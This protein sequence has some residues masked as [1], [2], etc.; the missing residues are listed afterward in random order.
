[1]MPRNSDGPTVLVTGAGGGV[2][3]S[4]LKCLQD[5]RYRVVA[6]DSDPHAAGLYA[7]AR[8]RVVPRATEPHYVEALKE[9][10][11]EEGAVLLFPGL[12]P[13]LKPLAEARA[14]FDAIGVTVVVSDPAVVST[15]D[16]K[17]ATSVLLSAAGLPAPR[18]ERLTAGTDPGLEPPYIHKPQKG[19]SG[20]QGVHVVRSQQDAGADLEA[21]EH[22]GY[23][24]QEY[25]DGPE[26][27]CGTVSIGGDLVGPIVMRRV[28]RTG[29]TYKAFVVRDARIE[30]TVQAAARA[31]HPFGACNFQLRLVDGD[32]YIFEIN[33]RC[34]G[35]T[36]ARALAGFNEP[37]MIADW[38]TLGTRPTPS[39]TEVGILRYW[40]ELLVPLDRIAEAEASGVTDGDGSTLW[41]R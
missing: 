10:A 5:S 30:A 39:I 37:R 7:A 20:S 16:D 1:M 12:D 25:L 26:Y 4:I 3:Q 9:V 24:V 17:L 11:R 18:T 38:I 27:T 40:D 21:R 22:A 2:G 23:V 32:A 34:S 19:G 14:E 41:R 8:G 13:E 33:A 36:G 29:D 31:L 28:L 15:A 6:L 35:T